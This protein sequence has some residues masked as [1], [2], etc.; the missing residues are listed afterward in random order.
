MALSKC[1][2]CIVIVL[3]SWRA[4]FLIDSKKARKKKLKFWADKAKN[5]GI[6]QLGVDKTALALFTKFGNSIKAAI[7]AA[8]N[9]SHVLYILKYE[10]YSCL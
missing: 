2:V 10:S 6:C 5:L 9:Q 1:L 8:L 7:Y 4:D 3:Y